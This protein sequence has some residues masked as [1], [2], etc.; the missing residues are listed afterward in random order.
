MHVYRCPY[1]RNN[2]IQEKYNLLWEFSLSAVGAIM[3]ALVRRLVQPGRREREHLDASVGD[4]D[5]MFELGR[6]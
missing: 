1:T 4:T 5:G 6:Q 3:S 2:C